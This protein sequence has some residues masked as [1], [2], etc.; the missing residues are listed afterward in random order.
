[1]CPCLT[2]LLRKLHAAAAPVQPGLGRRLRA[3]VSRPAQGY[4]KLQASIKAERAPVFAQV[5]QALNASLQTGGPLRGA[6]FWQWGMGALNDGDN[7]IEVSNG[8]FDFETIVTPTAQAVLQAALAAGALGSCSQ[9]CVPAADQPFRH[10]RSA[11]SGTPRV[12]AA[13]R[14]GLGPGSSTAGV[15]RQASALTAGKALKLGAVQGPISSAAGQAP[16]LT[17]VVPGV[18]TTDVSSAIAAATAG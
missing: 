15:H 17:P 8:D 7:N 3:E 2:M 6:L 9:V 4:A 1:M 18:G 5:Y 14:Q 10:A 16:P 13:S 12:A 11:G